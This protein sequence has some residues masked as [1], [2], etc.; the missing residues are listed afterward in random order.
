MAILIESDETAVEAV[1]SVLGAGQDLA[2]VSATADLPAL[3]A[4][5]P[6]E[7]LVLFGPEC[8]V[9]GALE[10]AAA[11]RVLRPELGVILIRRRVDSS[12]LGQAM[13]AGVR[14]VVRAGSAAALADACRR[15]QVVT[16]QVS[17]RVQHATPSTSGEPGQVVTVFS[18]KG[19]C[20]KT[21]IATNFAAALAVEKRRVCL[22]DLDLPFGDVAIMLQLYLER[23]I[24]DAVT[25]TGHMDE[26][27]VRSIVSTHSSGLDVIVAPLEP[28]D[29]ER[30]TP[31]LVTDL[32]TQL[33]SMYEV[34]VVDTPP[35]FTEPVLAALDVTDL[36]LL[37]ATLDIP[38]VKNLKLTLEMLEML[39]HPTDSQRII[40]NR[41]DAKVGLKVADVEEALHRPIAVEIPSSRD[42]PAAV[43]RGVPLVLD[44][45]HHPVSVAL[46]ALATSSITSNRPTAPAAEKS[47]TARRVPFLRRGSVPA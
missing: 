17:T 28:A 1:R 11:Q 38:A 37:V 30:I 43:N 4:G 25:M 46:R 8:D 41:A 24:A 21:T 39:N 18:A 31:A 13:R 6:D 26:V 14:E 47:A 7:S 22:V 34:V 12:L 40:V 35:A 27:G 44:Q 33:K 2:V 5:R 36:Y 19:G 16:A 42:V 10:F 3:L 15:S 32:L 29:A 20:G 45:P 9:D 23:T